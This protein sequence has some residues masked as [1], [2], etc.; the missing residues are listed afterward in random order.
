[1][2]KFKTTM[3]VLM[4]VSVLITV[5]LLAFL[6]DTIPVHYNIQG[7]VDRLGSKYESLIFPITTIG[8]GLFFLGMQKLFTNV[9]NKQEQELQNTIFFVSGV[10]TL[11]LFIGMGVYFMAKGIC[12]IS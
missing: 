9:T 11:L 3:Y 7:E 5:V 1:M 2:K 6:P 4:V 12:Y 10:A 8:M